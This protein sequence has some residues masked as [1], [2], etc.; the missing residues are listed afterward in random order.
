[1]TASKYAKQKQ[2]GKLMLEILTLHNNAKDGQ[3]KKQAWGI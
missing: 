1:M 2:R 3:K